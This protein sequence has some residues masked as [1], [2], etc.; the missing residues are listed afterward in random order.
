[1]RRILVLVALCSI[2]APAVRAEV[3]R[4]ETRAPCANA[5]PLRRPFFGDTHVHTAL[6]FDAM[7]QGT[8]AT[9]HDAYR[10]ARG[11]A[12]GVQPY[13]ADGKPL[14]TIQ[15]RRPL[16]FAVVTDHAE[17]L[18]ETRTCLDPKIAGFGSVVCRIVRR[19]PW[20]AYI[21]VNGSML[22]VAEP[23]R[24]GFCGENG[25]LC[26]E[27]AAKPWQEIQDAAE[28]HYDRSAACA[29][30][31]FVGYEWSGNPDSNMIHRNV[32]FRNAVAPAEPANFIDDRT[33]R[34]LWQRLKTE[35][36]EAGTGC[37]VL[38]IPH[39]TNL[40][41]GELFRE[42]GGDGAPLAA[43]EA[44]LRA[45]L[46]VLLEVNQ[47]KGDSECRRSETDPLCDFE[48]LPFATMRQ[49]ALP[50]TWSDAPGNSFA[51]EILGAGLQ[52]ERKIGVNPFKLGLIAASDTHLAAPGLVDEDRFVGHAAGRF[53]SRTEVPPLPDNWWFNPGGLAGVWAEE[54]SRD[55]LF[56]AM[57]RKEAWGTSGPRIVV[58]F[59]GGAD[60]PENLCD[61]HDFAAQGY[62]KGVPM[63]G[64]LALSAGA[65]AP[66]FAVWASR[67]PGTADHPGTPLERVQIVKLSLDATGRTQEHV[68]DVAGRP[69]TTGVVDLATCQTSGEGADQLCATWSDP[70]FDAATPALYYARV[71]ENPSCR[72]IQYACNERRI[73][74]NGSVPPGL[75]SCCD[76]SV[77]KTIQ[78]R[79]WTSPI[80]FTPRP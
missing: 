77:P 2:S 34:R 31:A 47:H 66:R 78:E 54:N 74:C 37:D 63:G 69:V 24:Y 71:V 59:F 33:G 64:D 67:D 56:E 11:E 15:L 49:S 80:W 39:N 7:A 3:E 21:L 10:F 35:C 1:M 50:W 40:S 51:R 48:K 29:F 5:D 61:A 53:T 58:R 36:L 28:R 52:Q 70:G 26:R 41:G 68:Y 45:S 12:I 65:T 38:V 18:G 13:G 55:A 27:A 8:R 62:A 44:E 76:A 60:L 73:D 16:D 19:W 42:T 6:S 14:R 22:D 43:P 46:E 23:R 4:T 57:R 32:V 9:P 30:T 75:E 20:L 79:A 17:L 25:A 72:W